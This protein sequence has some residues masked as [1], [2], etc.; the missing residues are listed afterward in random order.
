V[1]AAADQDLTRVTSGNAA[2]GSSP[3]S[4]TAQHSRQKA[5][6]VVESD[7]ID[8]VAATVFRDREE[9]DHVF[10]TRTSRQVW[11]D[12]G[13]TDRPNRIHFDLTLIHAVASADLDVGTCPYPDTA[14]DG[15]SSHSFPEPLGEDHAASLRLRAQLREERMNMQA[16]GSIIAAQGRHPVGLRESGFRRD[17]SA[18]FGPD[19]RSE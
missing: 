12:V 1:T 5:R 8:V 2:F 4:R 13:Q 14:G 17:P 9:V 7:Q 10:E 3:S 18:P 16:N 19:S 11:S 6:R 15:A